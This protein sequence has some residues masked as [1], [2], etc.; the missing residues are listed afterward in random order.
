M[1]FSASVKRSIMRNFLDSATPEVVEEE[2][3]L[4]ELEENAFVPPIFYA[5]LAEILFSPLNTKGSLLVS[6]TIVLEVD[7]E[8]VLDEIS[9]KHSMIWDLVLKRL[10]QHSVKELQ[11]I[12]I[13]PDILVCRSEHELPEGERRKI[14]LFCNVREEAV[15]PAL[16]AKSIYE[17]PIR[18]HEQGMDDVV[19]RHFGIKAA[20]PDLTTWKDIHVRKTKPEGEVSIAVVGKYTGLLDAY[21]SL[22]EALDHGG[23]ANNVRVKLN[24]IDSQIFEEDTP[25]IS[26]CSCRGEGRFVHQRC[27]RKFA[28]HN[29][30]ANRGAAFRDC[31]TCKQPYFGT[32]A[33]ALGRDHLRWAEKH[34]DEL[35]VEG[36]VDDSNAACAAW[37][38][39]DDACGDV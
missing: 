4:E 27:V 28:R 20:A 15:I 7:R 14:A 35:F 30:T 23:I 26:P 32:A 16:D 8:V 39:L 29:P 10:E 25:L 2:P 1:K 19:C 38:S 3:A 17:V 11:S 13:A 24:W 9:K 5:D 31:M 37:Q 12:G 22:S 18:Y 33:V 36:D 34:G 6:L 21:K